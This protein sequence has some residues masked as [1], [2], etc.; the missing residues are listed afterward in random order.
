MSSTAYRTGF[1]EPSSSGT[2]RSPTFHKKL[3]MKERLSR[4]EGLC[5]D[6]FLLGA[7]DPTEKRTSPFQAGS[8]GIK[9]SA[10]KTRRRPH[11]NKRRAQNVLAASGQ[12]K[13]LVRSEKALGK[14]KADQV[15]PKKNPQGRCPKNLVVPIEGPSNP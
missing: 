15:S 9:K 8:S 6:S 11:I 2:H 14:R 5:S 13:D 12:D 3:P 10:P 4:A 1:S 7:I